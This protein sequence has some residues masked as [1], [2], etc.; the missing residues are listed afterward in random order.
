MASQIKYPTQHFDD[1]LRYVGEFGW[2][3]KFLY[4][5]SCFL[6]IVSSALQIASLVFATGTPRFQCVT[7]N[8]TC[9]ENKCCEECTSYRFQ[10]SFSST[11]TEWNLICDKANIAATV[12]ALFVAG[13][14]AGSLM[15]GAV[16]DYFGRRFCLF[17]CSAL[18]FGFSLASSFVDC[19]SFFTFLRFCSGA[20]ITG[21]FVGHY[22][23]ILELVG[24]SYRT[25]AGKVQDVFWVIGACIMVMIAYLVRD[26]R[27]VL[28]IASFPAAL[29]YL[30]WRVFPES[31]R[32]LVIQG[33]LEDA[34]VILMK[35]ANKSCIEV[36]PHTVS[37]MLEKCRAS[38]SKL[39]AGTKRSP[40]D[41]VCTPRMRKRTLILCFNWMVL[42]MIFYGIM[43]YVP[44]L[45][46]NLYLNVFLMFVSDL[47]HT[48]MAWIAFKYFGRRVPHCIF[49]LIS[50][51]SCLLVLAVPEDLKGLITA[52]AIIGRFFGSASFSNI[53]LYSTELYPTTVRN[54][55]LGVCSTF[56]RIGGIVVPFIVALGQLPDASVALPLVIIGIMT[57]IAGIMSLWLPETLL[58]NMS[59]TVEDVEK[60]CENYGLIWMGKPRSCPFSFSSCFGGKNSEGQR[61]NANVLTD[62]TSDDVGKKNSFDSD[63]PKETSPLTTTADGPMQTAS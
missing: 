30:L 40:L 5:S 10:S 53:Y 31:L 21:L 12:Q 25:M 50:G 37:S 28:L 35:Y 43:L 1:V 24:A 16:S 55:A 63:D 34:H 48:P 17:L 23:Y 33:R 19:L 38:E 47:P 57:L 56:S 52:L 6:V 36:D 3:Q 61:D 44:S 41:L 46:G 54:M 14:M 18:A 39:K 13:M 29:F 62:I 51:L 26:W 9:D 11:V 58:S 8:V 60:S 49:M 42:N 32:W 59:E 2:W 20:A 45:A 4:F 27:H 15:F 22:V 7:P